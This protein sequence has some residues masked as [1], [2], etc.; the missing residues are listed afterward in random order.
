MAVQDDNSG[1]PVNTFSN[2]QSAFRDQANNGGLNQS[3][4]PSNLDAFES[5]VLE[6][7]EFTLK[8]LETLPGYIQRKYPDALYIGQLGTGK[9]N[10]KGV[11]RYKNGR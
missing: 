3:V 4:T 11:M 10:G 7:H 8:D 1:S 5:I 9:R 2:N 6:S